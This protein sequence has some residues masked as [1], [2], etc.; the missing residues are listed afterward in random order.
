MT[1]DDGTFRLDKVPVGTHTIEVGHE[2]L[3]KQEKKVTVKAGEETQVE[4]TF[5]KK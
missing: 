1:G 5:K 2:T 3:G 4:F